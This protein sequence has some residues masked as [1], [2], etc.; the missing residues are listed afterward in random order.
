MP[1][2]TEVNRRFAPD[3]YLGVSEL[4]ENDVV[5]DHVIVMRRLPSDRRL[6]RLLAYF[7]A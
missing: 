5:A 2:R 1:A 7:R 6:S 4:V 3:V